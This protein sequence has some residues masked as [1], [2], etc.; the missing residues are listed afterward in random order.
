MDHI[1]RFDTVEPIADAWDALA[2]AVGS[3]PFVRSGWTRCW[4]A[5][6]GASGLIVYTVWRDDQLAALAPLMVH[7]SGLHSPTNAHTP[8]WGILARDVLAVE[9]L[10]DAIVADGPSTITFCQFDIDATASI[11]A[12][13][14]L[15]DHGYRCRRDST[16][17]SPYSN[18]SLPWEHF[19]QR[20]S[21][22]RRSQLRRYERRLGD[23]GAITYED[24]DGRTDLDGL[25]ADGFRI[26]ASGWKGRQG[27][28]I[29]SQ[30]ATSAFYNDV[31]HWAVSEGMLRLAFLR[32]AGRPVAFEYL[33]DHR[34]T[35]YY[36]KAGY[37]DLYARW[38]PSTL[39]MQHTLHSA[40][41]EADT[42]LFEWLGH[43]DA[44]KLE[45]ADGVRERADV[46]WF[47]PT[48]RGGAFR[49]LRQVS[50]ALVGARGTVVDRLPRD[51]ITHLKELRGTLRRISA[52]RRSC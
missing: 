27:T 11:V 47:A 39:R 35:V 20:L 50:D 37:D 41:T 25:L 29:V 40:T 36:L 5:A 43:D 30:P 51:T 48:V 2:D 12:S 44:Y 31:A 16:M 8:V 19:K 13:K 24:A 26:E 17:R 3:T 32:I 7:G 21:S 52:G 23:G 46:R 22:R 14:A 45:W 15:E 33:L 18:V 34:A 28:A 42:H 49:A 10:V 6:F 9:S 1:R 4:L 38:S